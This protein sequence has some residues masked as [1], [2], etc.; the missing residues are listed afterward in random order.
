MQNVDE[1]C[2][3][4][5][6]NELDPSE[7]AIVEQAMRE[8]ANVLIEIESLR[9]TLRKLDNLPNVPPPPDVHAKVLEVAGEHIKARKRILPMRM[10][11][12]GLLAAAVV[13]IAFGVGTFLQT[14]AVNEE[15]VPLGSE[16][17]IMEPS[18]ASALQGL[19]PLPVAKK[20]TSQVDPWV[21]RQNVLR[22]QV[23]YGPDGQLIIGSE[24]GNTANAGMLKPV[25]ASPAETS[26]PV[27]RDIQ[28]TRTRQ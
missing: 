15:L 18:T 16:T 24:A 5:V 20:A 2:I 10:A 3:K 9:S 17:Q 27:M 4:Y 19:Q 21:D 7:V 26:Y 25:E 11:Y 6:M 23:S 1:L 8:D 28:L 14:D 22:I 12:T 13:V